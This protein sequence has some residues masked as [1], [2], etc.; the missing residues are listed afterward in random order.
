MKLYCKLLAATFLLYSCNN[1][2][3]NEKGS[4]TFDSSLNNE[5][6]DLKDAVAKFPDSI[7]L[8]KELIDYYYKKDDM[9]KAISTVNN[10]IAKDSNDARLWDFKAT[11]LIENEDTLGSIKAFEKAVSLYPA[12]EYLLSLGSAYAETKDPKALAVADLLLK[13]SAAKANKEANFIKGLYYNY[14]NNWPM[15]ISF[16]DKCLTE[17]YTFVFAYREKGIAL[18]NMGKYEEALTV[19]NRSITVQTSFDDGY[20]WMGRCLEKMNRVPEAIESYRTALQYNPDFVDAK[21][22]LANLGVK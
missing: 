14:I 5:E 9:N 20:Y 4:G 22:A 8:T 7:S 19:L 17:D 2:N 13:N 12:A 3:D 15:A 1:A 16:F 6:K 11:L 18:Y 21:D 10:A